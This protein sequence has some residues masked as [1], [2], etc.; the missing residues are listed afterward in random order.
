MAN[1][2]ASVLI[3]PTVSFNHGDTFAFGSWVCTTDGARSFQRR[4][5]M[6][7]NPRTGLVTLFE[8]ITGDLAG[9]FGEILLYNLHDDFEF[10]SASTRTRRPRGPSHAS[11]LLIHHVRTSH[12]MST[13]H[14]TSA[15]LA[16]PTRRLSLRAGPA[17]RS[18]PTTP[19]TPTLAPATTWT[20]P[21]SSTSAR[22]LSP[23]PRTPRPNNLC[24][25][26]PPVWL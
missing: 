5:T 14:T 15:T 9:K 21:T 3:K 24:Q 19:R 26:Q 23:S 18:S 22:T 6:T 12:F 16:R 7:L 1:S 2:T 25:D 8:V 20:P 10:G 11:R 4:L 17:R 13:T